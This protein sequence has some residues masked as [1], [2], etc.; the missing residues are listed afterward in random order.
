M[1][2]RKPQR[3]SNGI[4]F[5]I[6]ADPIRTGLVTSLARPGGNV[7]G[8]S[9]VSAELDGK[10]LEVLRELLPAMQRARTGNRALGIQPIFV[11][12]ERA[13]ELAH[14]VAEVAR[15]GGELRANIAS[16][17]HFL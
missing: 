3:K 11:E 2:G 5:A 16:P 15:R 13:G 10:R 6:A 9:I 1:V 17:S 8:Y 7:T 12:V 14:A 4:V